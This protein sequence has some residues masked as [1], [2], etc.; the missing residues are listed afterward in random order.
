MTAG[1]WP[2]SEEC[3]RVFEL[4]AGYGPGSCVASCVGVGAYQSVVC[5]Y[6]VGSGAGM[7]QE[8][9]VNDIVN[10]YMR[11]VRMVINPITGRQHL[12]RWYVTSDGTCGWAGIP[13]PE[14]D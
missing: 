13:W 10:V 9:P 11:R 7:D 5:P 6:L 1:H 3:R 4:P 2:R 8:E 14:S 12:Q